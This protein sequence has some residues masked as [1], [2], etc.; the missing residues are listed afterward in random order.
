MIRSV[1]LPLYLLLFYPKG[2][3][4]PTTSHHPPSSRRVHKS[5]CAPWPH[6]WIRIMGF[7]AHVQPCVLSPDSLKGQTFLHLCSL[8]VNV[9]PNPEIM[10]H[11]IQ[12]VTGLEKGS[13]L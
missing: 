4:A 5:R 6:Y 3:D 12:S 1:N 11:C 13:R 7:S 8:K 2:Q 9:E 10:D